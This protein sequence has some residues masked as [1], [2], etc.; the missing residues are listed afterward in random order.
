MTPDCH[1]QCAQSCKKGHTHTHAPA[2]NTQSLPVSQ[3]VSV[4]FRDLTCALCVPVDDSTQLT[5]VSDSA[6]WLVGTD[7]ER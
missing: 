5:D 6:L 3:S 7:G 1:R 2:Q 4:H